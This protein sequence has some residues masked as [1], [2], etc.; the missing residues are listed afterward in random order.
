M[1]KTI[2]QSYTLQIMVLFILIFAGFLCI[3]I[4]F[5]KTFKMKNEILNIIENKQGLTSVPINMSGSLDIINSYANE[6]GYSVKS[7]F[8]GTGSDGWYGLDLKP[9][10]IPSIEK[11]VKGTSYNICIKK[12]SGY[13]NKNSKKAYYNVQ[14][15]FKLDLP[16]LRDLFVYTVDGETVEIDRPLDGF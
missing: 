10:G 9:G 13:D 11:A 2:G 7:V 15:F 14:L 16:G 4:N 5:T 12:T 3:Y 8:S 1:K 6:N